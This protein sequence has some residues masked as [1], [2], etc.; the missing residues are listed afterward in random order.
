MLSI[1]LPNGGTAPLDLDDYYIEENWQGWDDALHFRLPAGH[2]QRKL[3]QE[4]L[5]ITDQESGQQYNIVTI[6]EGRVSADVVAFLNLD[7]MCGTIL[8]DYSNGSDTAYGTISKVVP[9]DW[10]V[11]DNSGLLYRRTIKL[12]GARPLDVI[13]SCTKTYDGL[14]V[15]FNNAAKLVVLYFPDNEKPGGAYFT[16][17]LN[18]TE[19][20]QYKGK[21]KDFYTRLY[22]QGKDGLTF[23]SINDGKPYVDC[24]DYTNRV[25]CRFWKDERYTDPESLKQAAQAAVKIAAV[26]ERSY[27]CSVVD[28]ARIDPERFSFLSIRMYQ[29]VFL[30]SRE[31]HTRI[32]HQVVRYRRYPHHPEKNKIV[33]STVP[34]TGSGRVAELHAAI[35]DT[36][37]VTQ[38]SQR[39]SA[40]IHGMVDSIAGYDGGNMVISKNLDGKPNGLMIMDTE[41]QTTAQKIL[42][43]N[44]KGI[45]YSD[46]GMEGFD[47]PDLSEITVWSFEKD[48]MIANWLKDGT[49]DASLVK[50]INL[51]ADHLRSEKGNLLL[52]VLSAALS[53]LE[54]EYRRAALFT[55]LESTGKSTG[56]LQL[57]EGNTK[58]GKLCD[59]DARMTDVTA[60]R[61]RIGLDAKGKAHGELM[62]EKVFADR[63]ST[64][65]VA[66]DSVTSSQNI[67]IVGVDQ[68]KSRFGCFDRLG[69]NGGAIQKVDWV[70]VPE[71]GKYVLCTMPE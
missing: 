51:I 67:P 31:P 27:E 18:L 42:W 41:N 38:F 55:E 61:V 40:M 8:M 12:D 71:L 3:L 13:Q 34:G 9:A 57:F 64:N 30:L 35:D 6:D 36:A 2:P 62:A 54:G 7:E 10:T 56:V 60:N 23:A 68:N 44:L 17:E 16:D 11:I 29:V 59:A 26:P 70:L 5:T 4:R 24:F 66:A 19:R 28:L 22:A 63:I 39:W 48:G 20:P 69:I 46:K 58:K 53:L 1:P 43:F 49:I 50:I 14:A 21:A 32:Q 37:G 47:N 52:E 45:L 15:R 65:S 25:I 33:L